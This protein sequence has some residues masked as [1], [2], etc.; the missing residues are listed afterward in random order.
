MGFN[1]VKKGEGQRILG[2]SVVLGCGTKENR[3]KSS[4]HG[5]EGEF[6]RARV[7][8]WN[9]QVRAPMLQSDCAGQAGFQQTN[10]LPKI[11]VRNFKC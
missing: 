10:L 8:C 11:Y 3:K 6:A 4:L 1:N 2:A 9:S 7:K 5:L